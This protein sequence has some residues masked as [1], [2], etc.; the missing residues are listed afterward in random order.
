M[1]EQIQ[2]PC[3]N[4]SHNCTVFKEA[5]EKNTKRDHDNNNNKSSSSDFGDVWGYDVD[6][7]G[8]AIGTSFLVIMAT[9]AH[10]VSEKSTEMESKLNVVQSCLFV[11]IQCAMFV[12]SFVL[13]SEEGGKLFWNGKLEMDSAI[14]GPQWGLAVKQ[15]INEF[16]SRS[17]R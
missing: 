17:L 12:G 14:W 7:R 5:V 13:E 3:R 1:V 2:W 9:S 16:T 11:H 10:L 6:N 15:K 4:W 8:G